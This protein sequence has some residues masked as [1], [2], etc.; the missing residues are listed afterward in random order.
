MWSVKKPHS[1]PRARM[2]PYR[3]PWFSVRQPEMT[4]YFAADFQIV[5][6]FWPPKSSASRQER[7]RPSSWK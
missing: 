6:F 4:A 3:D 2:R 1:P 7:R 5:F